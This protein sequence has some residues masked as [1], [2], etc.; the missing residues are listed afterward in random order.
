MSQEFTPSGSEQNPQPMRPMQ[1]QQPKRNNTWIYVAII[2]LLLGTNI[3][4]FSSRSKVTQQKEAAEMQFANS[5]SS[6]RSVEGEYNAALARLDELVSK[7]AQMDSLLTDRNSEVSKLKRQIDAIVKNKNATA[8]DLV[9]AKHLIAILNGKVKTYQERI[10][11]LEKQNTELTYQ[12]VVATH[13]RDSAVTENI[14]LQQKAKLGAVLHVS[15]I[16]M[17]PIQLKRG[18]TKEK[19]TTRASRVDILRIMFDIDENRVA[20]SG[21]KELFLKIIG[22]EGN[23]LSN[24]AYGSGVT[25]TADGQTLNYT[26]LKQIDLQTGVP[27]KDVTIDWHQDSDYKKGTYQIEIYNEGYKVGGGNV[28]L[29]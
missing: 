1:P 16:R 17:T 21:K 19:E 22:P 11:E 12:N 25:S 15:N 9:K 26:L 13:E 4:L 27:V 18:G 6:R 24:A 14:G 28:S 20:E 2:V 10:A 7:N 8:A 3:Y 5:D 23:V 29:R